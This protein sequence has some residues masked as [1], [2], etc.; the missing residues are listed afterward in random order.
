MERKGELMVMVTEK[1]RITFYQIGEIAL[2]RIIK[3]ESKEL[4][5]RNSYIQGI[6]KGKEKKN[7]FSPLV[8][9]PVG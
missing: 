6:E 9:D 7:Q 5:G 3:E 2:G 1:Y 4:D 8:T